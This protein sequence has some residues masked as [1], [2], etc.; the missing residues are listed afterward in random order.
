MKKTFL[1]CVALAFV[2]VGATSVASSAAS[3]PAM[4][5]AAMTPTVVVAGSLK[6][7]ADPQ[8]KGVSEAVLYGDPTKTG[9]YVMRYK[10]DNGVKFPAHW[11]TNTEQVTVL[12]GIFLV[13]IGDTWDAAK[14]TALPAG[15]FVS[16]PPNLHHYAQAKGEVIVQVT[17]MGPETMNMVKTASHM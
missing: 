12:S 17:G 9:V 4:M 14:M 7:T 1:F 5:N 10:L 8:M 6:W 16:V 2:I 3:G 11:H 13:G 15:S